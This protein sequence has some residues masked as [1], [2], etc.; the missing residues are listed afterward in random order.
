MTKEQMYLLGF[1]TAL[2]RIKEKAMDYQMDVA[3]VDIMVVLDIVDDL[4]EIIDGTKN[5]SDAF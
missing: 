4:R 2:D 5:Y 1:N 3:D